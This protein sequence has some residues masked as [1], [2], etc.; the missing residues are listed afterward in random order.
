MVPNKVK[1]LESFY[2]REKLGDLSTAWDIVL[3]IEVEILTF[4]TMFIIIYLD[5]YED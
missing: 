5:A 3:L 1:Q 2:Y 4:Q